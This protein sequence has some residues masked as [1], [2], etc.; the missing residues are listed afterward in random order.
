MTY[1]QLVTFN[2]KKNYLMGNESPQIRHSLTKDPLM[3]LY[4]GPF[5]H[6]TTRSKVIVEKLYSL[7][8]SCSYDRVEDVDNSMASAVAQQ[9]NTKDVVCPNNLCNG[10]IT[11]ATFDNL[12]VNLS[13]FI[14]RFDP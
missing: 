13:S 1:A 14:V 5:V 6:N 4:L 7:V 2:T 9:A 8:L 10:M 11:G 3:L 12:E